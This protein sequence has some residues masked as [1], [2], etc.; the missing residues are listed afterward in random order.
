M[1]KKIL[2]GIVAAAFTLGLAAA[3]AATA[4][5]TR[6]DTE[7]F[8]AAL[9][10]DGINPDSPDKAVKLGYRI[11]T[12][13]RSGASQDAVIEWLVNPPNPVPLDQATRFVTDA[14]TYLCPDAP[15]DGS[16]RI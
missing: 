2:G 5:S 16:Q 4:D 12:A 3:P 15:I 8:I 14:H 9:H 7:A 10:R 11:C 1:K 13:M 6:P